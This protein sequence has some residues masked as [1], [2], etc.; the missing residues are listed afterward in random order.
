MAVRFF[1]YGVLQDTPLLRIVLGR[2][3]ADL[4]F[5]PAWTEGYAAFRAAGE[6]FPVLV[7]SPGARLSGTLAGG[8]TE[9]DTARIRFFEDS[10]YALS[11]VT[12]HTESGPETGRALLLTDP[13]QATDEPWAFETWPEY[14]RAVLRHMAAAFMDMMGRMTYEDADKHW[15]ELRARARAAVSADG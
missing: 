4:S 3:G 10:F 11:S 15:E 1:F 8:L 14:E 7:E 9:A 13:A 2:D 6:T 12:V 5:T